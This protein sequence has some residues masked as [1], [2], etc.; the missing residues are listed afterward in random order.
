VMAGPARLLDLEHQP[1]LLTAD[2]WTLVRR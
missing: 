2:G 1:G